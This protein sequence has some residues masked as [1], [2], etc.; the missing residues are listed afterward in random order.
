M[1]ANIPEDIWD[2]SIRNVIAKQNVL[3]D[4]LQRTEERSELNFGIRKMEIVDSAY[5][6][7]TPCSSINIPAKAPMRKYPRAALNDAAAADA[8]WDPQENG[9]PDTA[10]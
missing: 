7:G 5:E 6:K 3:L 10:I 9:K 1:A 8:E 4:F 2:L